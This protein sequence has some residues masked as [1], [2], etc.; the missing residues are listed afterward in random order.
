MSTSSKI[1]HYDF[2]IHAKYCACGGCSMEVAEIA[3]HAAAAGTTAIAITDHVNNVAMLEKHRTIPDDIRAADS[4]LEIFFG[5]EVNFLDPAQPLPFTQE[6]KAQYGVQFAIGGPHH[7]YLEER[8]IPKIIDAV[9]RMHLIICENP[10]IDVLVH[11]YW[12]GHGSFTPKGWA[13]FDVNDFKK[14]PASYARELGQAA[15]A[16]GTA[17]EINASAC[18]L[19]MGG[20]DWRAAY[21]DYLAII[22]EQGATFSTGSDSHGYDGLKQ[23][24]W[25]WNAAERLGLDES[26]IFRPKC[27]PLNK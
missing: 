12:F 8:D 11:P 3:R 17:V 26:R 9:H 15:V 19:A 6:L 27:K 5:V 2:H 4:D 23:I 14:V 13:M 24:E 16:T 20:D 1:P 21:M 18:F 7:H 10:L 22:A 25:S